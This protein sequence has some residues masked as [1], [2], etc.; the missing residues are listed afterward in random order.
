[1]TSFKSLHM[2]FASLYR[3]YAVTWEELCAHLLSNN[4]VPG[5]VLGVWNREVEHRHCDKYVSFGSSDSHEGKKKKLNKSIHKSGGDGCKEKAASF[6]NK[7][8]LRLA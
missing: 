3:V 1:M 2:G 4:Y 6:E 7:M 8:L 5:S